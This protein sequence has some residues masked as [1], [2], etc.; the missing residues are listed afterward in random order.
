MKNRQ[1]KERNKIN[2]FMNLQLSFVNYKMT[3]ILFL[4]YTEI[5]DI[6]NTETGSIS[7]TPPLAWCLQAIKGDYTLHERLPL[8]LSYRLRSKIFIYKSQRHISNISTRN[9]L[10]YHH[11]K[12]VPFAYSLKGTCIMHLHLF[13]WKKVILKY[14]G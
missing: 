9:Y 13:P 14:L 5:A 1:I 4:P 12:I 3:K 11:R 6:Q 7:A 10:L 2:I 8:F